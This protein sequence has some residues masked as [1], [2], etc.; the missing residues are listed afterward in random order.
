MDI[1][2]CQSIFNPGIENEIS[3]IHT[4][5]KCAHAYKEP[6]CKGDFIVL[7]PYTPTHDNLQWYEGFND[8]IKSVGPCYQD[9]HEEYGEKSNETVRVVLYA[10][11][12]HRG[13]QAPLLRGIVIFVANPN[14]CLRFEIR[15][16]TVPQNLLC[17]PSL[18]EVYNHW[19]RSY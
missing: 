8:Q 15:V 13:M 14:L 17:L 4:Y 19:N 10:H 16:P 2:K 5:H 3:S 9:C 7:K 12:G 6:E 1:S 18:H 11:P